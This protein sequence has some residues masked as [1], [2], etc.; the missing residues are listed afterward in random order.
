[1]WQMLV[2]LASMIGSINKNKIRCEKD[3]I[4][5]TFALCFIIILSI[6]YHPRSGGREERREVAKY[7]EGHSLPLLLFHMSLTFTRKV[8]IID[9]NITQLQQNQ[10]LRV[11]LRRFSIFLDSS[12]LWTFETMHWE[13]KHSLPMF[14]CVPS[15]LAPYVGH[16]NSS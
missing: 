8:N 15:S 3:P 9:D 4:L 12:Y 13:F 10:S 7:Y 11:D 5:L 14:P 16:M 2:P 6:F 1:M